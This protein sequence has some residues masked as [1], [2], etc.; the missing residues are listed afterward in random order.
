MPASAG[1][2]GEEQLATEWKHYVNGYISLLE[3]A[4]LSIPFELKI[5][6]GLV[7][8]FLFLVFLIVVLWDAYGDEISELYKSNPTTIDAHH[9]AEQGTFFR[10]LMQISGGIHP[11][12]LRCV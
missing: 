5:L 6:G 10:K 2:A 7:L 11:T 3:P 12:A 9:A 8:L 4:S 1:A